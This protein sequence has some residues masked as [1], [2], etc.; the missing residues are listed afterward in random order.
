MVKSLF[1]RINE[2]LE[3]H[4]NNTILNINELSI[5]HIMPQSLT[6]DWQEMLG[7]NAKEIH[8]NY[9]HTLGNLT[10]TGNNSNLSNKF[11]ERKSGYAQ[12]F[13]YFETA[14]IVM[15]I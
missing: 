2:T 8:H 12:G 7:V 1:I 15:Q 11:I 9:L 4:S 10:L 5:E 14:K 13:L 3:N 6:S